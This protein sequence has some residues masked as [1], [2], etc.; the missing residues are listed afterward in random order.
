MIAGLGDEAQDDLVRRWILDRETLDLV[1]HARREALDAGV[2]VHGEPCGAEFGDRLGRRQE[3]GFGER[4]L[5][6]YLNAGREELPDVRLVAVVLRE[7]GESG[8]QDAPR[9]DEPDDGRCAGSENAAKLEER[10]AAVG[11]LHDVVHR[12]EHERGIERPVRN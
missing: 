11:L 5:L 3:C 8:A 2:R 9:V 1:E 10:R 7:L 4:L 6:S 12:A